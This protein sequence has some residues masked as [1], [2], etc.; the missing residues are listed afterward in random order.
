MAMVVVVEG[1]KLVLIARG[2]RGLCGEGGIGWPFQKL[3]AWGPVAPLFW[4]NLNT[5]NSCRYRTNY[6]TPLHGLI[7]RS[8]TS[9]SMTSAQHP[10]S[11][12]ISPTTASFT[13]LIPALSDSVDMSR[14]F[15]TI[16]ICRE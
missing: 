2:E 14:L 3:F 9:S 15:V 7:P 8:S 1:Q 16:Q 10:P 12:E 11:Y 13:R 6:P 5:G 4:I